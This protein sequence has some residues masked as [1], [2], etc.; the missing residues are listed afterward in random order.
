M[1]WN[2]TIVGHLALFHPH[3]T[4][5]DNA[6]NHAAWEMLQRKP[7]PCKNEQ[8]LN[9]KAYYFKSLHSDQLTIKLPG[10]QCGSNKL[11]LALYWAIQ[12]QILTANGALITVN[13]ILSLLGIHL[14]IGYININIHINY[15]QSLLLIL[16]I[17]YYLLLPH[18]YNYYN[19]LLII[20]NFQTLIIFLF[21]KIDL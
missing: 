5:I 3:F 8:P 9:S 1:R 12:L 11:A 4:S 20:M 7:L 19:Y 10:D 17:S 6:Q 2:A 14:V 18:F 16:L 15:Y 13:T 21:I